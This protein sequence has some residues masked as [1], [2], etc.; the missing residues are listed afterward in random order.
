MTR[1]NVVHFGGH[2]QCSRASRRGCNKYTIRLIAL[3][4]NTF[5]ALERAVGGATGGNISPGPL[6]CFAFSALERAVGGATNLIKR[7]T[8]KNISPLSVLSSE[9]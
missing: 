7:N 6:D 8:I 3:D 5:S 9:P 2:F 1:N 4:E